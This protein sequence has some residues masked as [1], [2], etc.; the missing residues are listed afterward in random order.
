LWGGGGEVVTRQLALCSGSVP[1]RTAP[2]VT[3]SLSAWF[4]ELNTVP[5]DC[6]L[7][8]SL[9]QTAK[10][11]S[12]ITLPPKAGNCRH[13]MQSAS[14]LPCSQQPAALPYPDPDQFR[15]RH[16]SSLFINHMNII[17]SSI[18][19]SSKWFLSFRSGYENSTNSTSAVFQTVHIHRPYFLDCFHYSHTHTHTHTHSHT[20]TYAYIHDIQVCVCVCIY[21][22]IYIY[23]LYCLEQINKA[24]T[25]SNRSCQ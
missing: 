19:R 4:S 11:V 8:I 16:S 7:S 18:L 22:Y 14:S 10:R 2:H 20:H 9:G 12:T 1:I 23:I 6:I 3:K 17:L 24:K 25:L 21:I 15:P 13:F 5:F